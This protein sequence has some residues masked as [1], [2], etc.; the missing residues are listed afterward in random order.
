MKVI[1]FCLKKIYDIL[2]LEGTK[3]LRL[4]AYTTDFELGL[5][6]V[7][8][9]NLLLKDLKNIS[10]NMLHELC[11]APFMISND[12]NYINWQCQKYLDKNDRFKGYI[13]YY[14]TQWIRYFNNGMLNYSD[15]SKYERSNSYRKLQ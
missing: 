15:I 11:K 2:T 9:M 5:I 6:K 14:K 3:E 7:L 8:Q 10:L 13:N 12:K 1:I 4:R